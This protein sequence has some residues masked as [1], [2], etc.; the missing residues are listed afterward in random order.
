MTRILEYDDLG[1]YV[2]FSNSG[3][4]LTEYIDEVCCFNKCK[5]DETLKNTRKFIDKQLFG[6]VDDFYRKGHLRV[7]EVK[8]N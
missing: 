8:E 6:K 4:S 1:L 7:R 5:N 3:Y 2:K